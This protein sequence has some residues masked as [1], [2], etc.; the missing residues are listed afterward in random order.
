MQ[1]PDPVAA[2]D[3]MENAGLTVG[4]LQTLH[5]R[6]LKRVHEVEAR[7][8]LKRWQY[9]F[10]DLKKKHDEL[11]KEFTAVY[12]TVCAQLIDLFTRCVAFDQKVSALHL[13]RPAGLALHLDTVELSA[14]ELERFTRDVPSLLTTVTLSDFK[15]G[16]Q[17]WPP[18]QRRDMSAFIPVVADAAHSPDWWRPEVQAARNAEAAA[19]AQRVAEYYEQ[20]N[21]QREEREKHG[22]SP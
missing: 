8:R 7:E 14:R 10:R 22:H 1:A 18:V 17:L 11:V 5:G 4:R 2:R 15:T 13:S 3:A 19:E 16:K 20:Q 21:K 12:P 9:E 6:L